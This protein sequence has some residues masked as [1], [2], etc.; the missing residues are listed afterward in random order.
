MTDPTVSTLTTGS[1]ATATT[2]VSFSAQTAG[3]L[4]LL[5]VSSDDYKTG[6]P[7]G[8][9]LAQSG[10]DF[11]GHYLW[12]KLSNGSETSVQYTIG[13]A[14]ASAYAAMVAD[15]IDP[16][17]F[18]AN[19]TNHPHGASSATTTAITPTAGPRYLVVASFGAMHAGASSVTAPASL[20]NSFTLQAAGT[21]GA[22]VSEVAVLGYRTM[23]GGASVSV[24]TSVWQT[25][26]PQ[27]SYGL[28]A[29]F[30]VASAVATG[31]IDSISW[32]GRTVTV[33]GSGTT[34]A[35]GWNWGDGNTST[36]SPASHTYSTDGL[37]KIDLTDAGTVAKSTAGWAVGTAAKDLDL[38]PFRER[39]ES[40][41]DSTTLGPLSLLELFGSGAS[42][43]TAAGTFNITGAATGKATGTAAGTVTLNG[44]GIAAGTAAGTGALTLTGTAT[45]SSFATA[46][47][48]GTLA[49]TGNATASAGSAAAGTL[50]LTGSATAA[51]R[52]Q[53]AGALNITGAGQ[54]SGT[55]QAAGTIAVTGATQAAGAT[56][57]A[58]TITITGT[59]TGNGTATATTGTLN[60]T[61]A[62]T[63]TG[64][65]TPTAAGT[66]AIT[67]A[68]TP[69]A[70]ANA[71]GTITITGQTAAVGRAVAAGAVTLT[72][73]GAATGT[74]TIAGTTNITGSSTP[75]ARTTAAGTLAITGAANGTSSSSSTATGGL[76]IT[77]AA[78][79]A[80]TATANGNLTIT[81]AATGKAVASAVGFLGIL[82][83]ALALARATAT[84][85]FTIDGTAS[86]SSGWRD[87]TIT[88]GQPVNTRITAS[89][90]GNRITTHNPTA[91]TITATDT[92]TRIH[93]TQPTPAS[94]TTEG[95]QP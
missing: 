22:T 14:T 84:D 33:N 34:G 46:T 9:T 8:W 64:T 7:S 24:D 78:T 47:A 20:T 66:L 68:A 90:T 40:D 13:S 35:L 42:G 41:S 91:A 52:A 67:G 43:S 72:G 81:G 50:T 23:D 18:D 25:N 4:L 55:G 27:C 39:K 45:G 30:K 76:T 57:A 82:G 12:W 86:S 79:G 21:A 5:S 61:G 74:T 58:G 69:T 73:T 71:A 10:Q 85:G 70:T 53:S 54:A 36:G 11:Q 26:A 88:V 92:P 56:A 60:V 62:A 16:T 17:P 32:S 28:L 51:G 83:A 38:T 75:T 2:T 87:I 80:A 37:Y 48:S 19:S 59:T 3:K 89:N 95:A 77:G 94:I 44:S 15:N 49:I 6:D 63:G 29:A 65:S 31:T 93:T 1:S